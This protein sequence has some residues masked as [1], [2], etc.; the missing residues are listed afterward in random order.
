MFFYDESEFSDLR[1]AFWNIIIL[2]NRDCLE[3]RNS[4]F[5]EDGE[6]EQNVCSVLFPFSRGI[7]ATLLVRIEVCFLKLKIKWIFQTYT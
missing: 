6:R 4:F 2:Y 5:L 3:Q 7:S 1:V